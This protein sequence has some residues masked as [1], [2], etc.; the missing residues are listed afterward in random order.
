[1]LNLR[2]VTAAVFLTAFLM[3]GGAASAAEMLTSDQ[4]RTMV[5]GNTVQGAMVATGPYAEFYQADGTIKGKDYTG[6][7]G[8]DGDKMCFQYGTD[9]Q[10]CWQVGRDG[11]AVQWIKDGK[12]E[13]T[14]TVA[15]GNPNNF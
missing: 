11:D 7:W 12:V 10:S 9:P 14:G 15:K 5:S 1:M 3:Y 2:S 6:V 13:G 4:I 8:I